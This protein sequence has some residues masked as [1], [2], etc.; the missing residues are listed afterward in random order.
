MNKRLDLLH[1]YPF[2]RLNELLRGVSPASNYNFIPLS[3]GEPQHKTPDFLIDFFCDEKTVRDG[4]GAYPPTRGIPELRSAIADFINQRFQLTS[5]P[6]NAENQVLPVSGTREALFSIAQTI[7]DPGKESTTLLP[8]PFYQIYEGAALLAG[9]QPE[10]VPCTQKTNYLPDFDQVDESTWQKCQLL[11]ICT[12]GNPTGA[13][14]SN[15]DLQYLSRMSDKYDFVIASDECYSEIY[16]DEAKPPTGLLQAAH[17]MG[18]ADYKNCMSFNSLSKRSNLPGLRSGYVAGDAEMLDKYLLYRTYHGAAMPIHNQNLSSIAWAD[19][20]HVKDNRQLYREKFSAVM[21][22]LG[23]VW[24]MEI[25]PASFYLW[26][27][28][29]IDDREF[30]RKLIQHTNIKVVPGSF[31][32]REVRNLNPGRNRIR[33]ALVASLDECVDAAGRLKS[34]IQGSQYSG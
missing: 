13:V 7:I 22:I 2:E 4:L 25:P 26:P 12:P 17:D 8:N 16:A 20:N 21:D 24:E 6:I 32:S 3:M 18:R 1:P 33:M 34:F 15:A 11:Y 14:M 30:T 28:T 19:E 9:S 23:P 27:E 29:P 10:Y 5:N 31:L